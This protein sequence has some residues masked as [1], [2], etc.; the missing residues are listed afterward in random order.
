MIPPYAVDLFE[1][2]PGIGSTSNENNNKIIVVL[3]SK[4]YVKPIV[5]RQIFLIIGENTTE[6]IG[7]FP[8]LYF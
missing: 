7:V 2:M 8:T 6:N 5:Y 3:V 1:R 4:Q